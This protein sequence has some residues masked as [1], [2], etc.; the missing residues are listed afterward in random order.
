MARIPRHFELTSQNRL[1]A[2]AHLA[3]RFFREV[4]GVDYAE[5]L[6]T[7]ESD[8]TDFT[9]TTGDR[10][11][12]VAEMLAR[13]ATHYRIT[14]RPESTRIVDLLESLASKGVTREPPALQ[15]RRSHGP[16]AAPPVTS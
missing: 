2:V 4:V 1:D 7:D 6:V 10:S 5:V 8:L 16:A 12:E 14:G 9:D 11:L 3:R 13:M 15:A